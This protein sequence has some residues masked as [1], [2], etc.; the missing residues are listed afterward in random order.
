MDD[1]NLAVYAE[2]EKYRC[3][4]GLA[5][6]IHSWTRT[7][8]DIFGSESS[9]DV[10]SHTCLNTFDLMDDRTVERLRQLVLF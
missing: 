9:F 1:F 4:T 2:D 7:T 3:D 10:S 5:S 6:I 8:P